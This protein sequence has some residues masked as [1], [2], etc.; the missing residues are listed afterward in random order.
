MLDTFIN[1]DWNINCFYEDAE[2]ARIVI[3]RFGGGE[4]IDLSPE[5]AQIIR[6]ALGDNAES[7]DGF[8]EDPTATIYFLYPN[9]LGEHLNETEQRLVSD[10]IVRMWHAAHPNTRFLFAPRNRGSQNVMN[11]IANKRRRNNGRFF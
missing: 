7:K 9:Q 2:G 4:A 5:T 8:A 3:H 10:A 1:L 6:S 11:R